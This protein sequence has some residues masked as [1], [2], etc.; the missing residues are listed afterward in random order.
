MRKRNNKVA[1]IG[2]GRTRFGELFDRSMISLVLEAGMEALYDAKVSREEL[3]EMFIGT[4][5]PEI[6]NDQGNFSAFLSEEMGFNIPITRVE[7]ACASG[8]TAIYNGIRAIK[9]G[10]CD[11]VLVGGAEKATDRSARKAY[12]AAASEWERKYSFDFISLNAILTQRYI[13]EYPDVKREDMALISVKNHLHAADNPNAHFRNRITEEMVMKAPVISSPVRLL[14][15]SP[16]S[17]GA[18]AVILASEEKARELTDNPVFL[19]G[20]GMGSDTIGLY[21]RE[22]LTNLKASRETADV[23]F[24]RSGLELRDI[25]IFEMHDAYIIQEIMGVEDIGLAERGKAPEM[26]REAFDALGKG[27]HLLHERE[28]H[29][30]ITNCG[31]GLKADGHPVGATGVRQIE[32][33]YHQI[34]GDSTHPVGRSL[35][36]DPSVGL[37]QNIGGSGSHITMM[38]M[39]SEEHMK[40]RD[41]K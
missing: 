3:D 32:E 5:V 10:D 40:G 29:S 15:C 13:H 12:M 27:K 22:S 26:M 9:S 23:A 7:S 17:D 34:K 1:L 16:V 35:G 36:R 33:I 30:F 41:A 38:I 14:D 20:Y 4:F 39:E 28:G 37:A 11:L 19:S 21:G 24:R 18:A 8:G 25:D 31:G 2:G 6:L